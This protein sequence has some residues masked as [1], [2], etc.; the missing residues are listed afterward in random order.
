M[1]KLRPMVAAFSPALPT[2]F[3]RSA[4]SREPLPLVDRVGARQRRLTPGNR[5][6]ALTPRRRSPSGPRR[7]PRGCASRAGR[8]RAGLSRSLPRAGRPGL[9]PDSRR[10][11]FEEARV[12]GP[13]ADVDDLDAVPTRD[14]PPRVDDRRSGR[15]LPVG[16][17]EL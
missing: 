6:D 5:I 13:Y 9:A 7:T 15:K 16:I 1:T 4:A 17:G 14:V 10:R 3:A 12:R 2:V 11:R 8:L